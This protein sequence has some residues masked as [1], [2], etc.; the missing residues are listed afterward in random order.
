MSPGAYRSFAGNDRFA[1]RR[2]LGEGGM[3]VVYEAYDTVS[4]QVVALKTLIRAEPSAVYQLKNEFRSLADVAHPN[5]VCLFELFIEADL[6]FFTMELI[7]G[8]D[9]LSYA[10]DNVISGSKSNTAVTER[11]TLA[12]GKQRSRQK[13]ATPP[14]PESSPARPSSRFHGPR[15]SP[16]KFDR[17]WALL[18]QLAEGLRAL[19]ER[20]KLHRDIKPS[21]ILVD[22]AGRVVLLDFGLATE[23][24]SRPGDFNAIFA[25][26]PAYSSPEQVNGDTLSPA[27]DWYGVG[28]TLYQALTGKL[29]FEGSYAAMITHK[30]QSDPVPPSLLVANV[31]ADLEDLCMAL[32]RRD[33]AARPSGSNVLSRLKAKEA[34]AI[35][36]PQRRR[37]AEF[38]GREEQLSKLSVAFNAVKEGSAAKVLVHGSSGIGKSTLVR[39]F[40]RKLEQREQVLAL[41]GRCFESES[42]P[43]K[44]LDG[45]VDALTRYLVSL[46]GAQAEALLPRDVA[47]MA[48]MFPVLTHVG[49]IAG[50]RSPVREVADPLTLRRRAF[51]S[52]RELLARISDR[53]PVVL[54]IDDLHWS[55]SD[56]IILLENLLG[57]PD[58]PVLLLIAAFRTEEI[59][60]VPF[61]KSLLDQAKEEHCFVINL[62]GLHSGEVARLARSLLSS[63]TPLTEEFLSS[64]D[65]EAQG[66]PFLIEQLARWASSVD[67]P[68]RYHVSLAE[69]LESNMR[70]LPEGARPILET[71]SIAARPMPVEVALRASGVQEGAQSLL[72]FLRSANFLRS[73][74]AHQLELYHDR[75]RVGIASRLSAAETQ[76]I[77]HRLAESLVAAG[78][79][80]PEVLCEHHYGARHF[81]AAAKYARLAAAKAS[82]ALAF[83]RA[84]TFCR[85][86]LDLVPNESSEVAALRAEMGQALRNAGRPA[87]AARAYLA[88]AQLS[89]PDIALDLQRRAAEQLL[90]GGHFEEGMDVIRTVLDR[91]G[92]RLAR[93][94][95]SALVSLLFRRFRLW[96]RGFRFKETAAADIPPNVLL[97]IDVCWTVAIG[98]ALVDLIRGAD[99]QTRH[100]LLALRAGEPYRIAR[101]LAVEAG[102]SAT[103]GA[104]GR[105]RAER[106]SSLSANLSTRVG[107]P[108][109]TAMAKLMSGIG[110]FLMGE[111]RHA[112]E[113]LEAA[114]KI[115]HDQCTGVLWEMTSAQNFMLGSLLYLGEFPD[116]SRRLPSMLAIAKERGNLYAT[117]DITTRMNFMWLV[118]DDPEAARQD[119]VQALSL[120]SHQGFYLQHYNALLAEA[121]ID[122]YTGHPD[123]A[124][125]RVTAHW[126]DLRRTMLLRTQVLRI[127]AL[128]LKARSALGIAERDARARA[129]LL[130]NVEHLSSAVEREHMLWS[131]PLA[132][133][134]RAGV[135]VLRR[136]LDRAEGLLS[137][138]AEGF[139][140]SGM[141]LHV[142]V[143]EYRLGEVRHGRKDAHLGRQAAQWMTKQGIKNIDGML[144][145]LAPGFPE[146][147]VHRP[148]SSPPPVR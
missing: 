91:V 27:S 57:P 6:C 89:E 18:R 30:L 80:D 58:A 64:I 71:L 147:S 129:H 20:E 140:Q 112:V 97:H 79:D 76:Q 66:N 137:K 9:F 16:A 120:W 47:A 136:D 55:D 48:K 14:V 2:L 15:V 63:Q 35:G 70:K 109:A 39:T 53:V 77:H 61:L 104:P 126:D 34:S 49:A 85:R 32:L 59:P 19:H 113:Q 41:A 75:I 93:G 130:K 132:W 107:N 134:L 4:K 127:E 81:E 44:A 105:R 143:A 54:F 7:D 73:G 29:P 21:N 45:I 24:A 5:L 131:D 78:F 96:V 26:T 36:V 28:V 50:Y 142:A 117:R 115:L 90:L 125:Q 139:E 119:L 31:P 65:S 118:A 46:P 37:N 11:A 72:T 98:L 146:D 43:Y 108:H 51:A 92:L 52:L 38:V 1:V 22:R 23:L 40:I 101:A 116:V 135:A 82:A 69:V 10:T 13:L 60:N 128:A 84:A 114:Y 86:A 17:L 3:G 87:E 74:A 102:F 8:V 138:A 99:F 100:L 144:R 25:G 111:W 122:L 110:K 83:D 121:Q 145:M 124:L 106:F 88:A 95:K 62:E 148:E 56:S 68:G 42:I 123:M 33:P 133:M 67:G 141:A 12:A 94:P 103:R